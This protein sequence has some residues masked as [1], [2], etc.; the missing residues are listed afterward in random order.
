MGRQHRRRF[1]AHFRWPRDHCGFILIVYYPHEAPSSMNAHNLGSMATNVRPP[2][3]CGLTTEDMAQTVA[4]CVLAHCAH[5]IVTLPIG[6][7]QVEIGP[8]PKV[9]MT[10]MRFRI[11][12]PALLING[13]IHRHLYQMGV[14][15]PGSLLAAR[16]NR[17]YLKNKGRCYTDQRK[18]SEQRRCGSV[19]LAN[20]AKP[21]PITAG[22]KAKPV[23]CE[24]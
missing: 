14:V 12:T 2:A 3:S 5:Q 9:G 16:L 22:K 4:Q 20:V 11:I 8:L 10:H 17:S 21:R 1:S 18:P 24:R 23:K 13:I 19:R 6:H 15:F 7:D